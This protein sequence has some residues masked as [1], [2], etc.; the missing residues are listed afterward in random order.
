MQAP[1]KAALA[2]D[3]AGFRL[4]LDTAGAAMRQVVSQH[5][6]WHLTEQ[7]EVVLHKIEVI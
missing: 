3:N 6:L 1:I 7:P 5:L 2:E 4:D